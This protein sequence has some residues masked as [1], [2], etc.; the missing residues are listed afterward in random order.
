[1]ICDC[2]N[3]LNVLFKIFNGIFIWYK[4]NSLKSETQA[5]IYSFIV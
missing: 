5:S 2:Q 1:M 3:N 4:V